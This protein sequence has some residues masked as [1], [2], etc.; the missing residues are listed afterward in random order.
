MV[1]APVPPVSVSTLETV[2][3]LRKSPRTSLSVPAPRS[4]EA[5][6]AMVCRVTVSLVEPPM[7]VSTFE[8]EA[9]LMKSPRVSVSVPVPRLIETFET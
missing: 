9:V 2:A 1:S 6:E 8:T 4:I 3:V 5:F 7:M